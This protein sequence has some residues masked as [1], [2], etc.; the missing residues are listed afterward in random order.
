MGRRLQLQFTT[1]RRPLL[2]SPRPP[3]LCSR[4]TR[5]FST[6]FFARAIS[7]A[8]SAQVAASQYTTARSAKSCHMAYHSSRKSRTA[9]PTQS[10]KRIHAPTGAGVPSR[11]FAHLGPHRSTTTVAAAMNLC[12]NHEPDGRSNP[13]RTWRQTMMAVPTPLTFCK[14]AMPIPFPS[15]LPSSLWAKAAPFAASFAAA[16][17]TASA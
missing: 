14:S 13:P 6:S 3:P 4:H 1:C 7:L 15:V 2:R 17:P 10:A 5:A 9:P 11:R 16:R 8:A 12:P